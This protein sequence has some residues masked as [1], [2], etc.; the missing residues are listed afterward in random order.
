MFEVCATLLDSG[1]PLRNVLNVLGSEL[2]GCSELSTVAVALDC[3]VPWAVAWE[4]VPARL[5]GLGESLYF[6]ELT[7]APAAAMLRAGAAAANREM[8]RAAE[9]RAAAFGVRLVLPL[10]LCA[11]PAFICLGV[12]PLVISLLPRA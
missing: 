11:L 8:S 2:P 6:T 9:E 12:V 1:L 4:Q 7:G 5:R 10:G 3:Q